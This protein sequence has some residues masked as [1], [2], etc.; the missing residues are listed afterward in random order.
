MMSILLL[1]TAL[2]APPS[3]A[4][5]WTF[6]DEAARNGRSMVT[7]RT[8]ELAATPTRPLDAA[9]KPPAGSRFGSVGVGPGGRHRL[10]VVWHAASNALWFDADGDGRFAAAERHV[11]GDKP[12]E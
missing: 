12:V 1:S 11:L 5:D 3:P 9:D 10:G 7:F 2:A 8:V 4:G 6:V